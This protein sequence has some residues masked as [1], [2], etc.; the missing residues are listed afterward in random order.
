MVGM[1]SVKWVYFV[2]LF[3]FICFKIIFL[4]F[5]KKCF[6]NFWLMIFVYCEL[7]CLCW[8]RI[9][10]VCCRRL[11]CMILICW[12]G[13]FCRWMWWCLCWLRCWWLM[14]VFCFLVLWSNVLYWVGC[15]WKCV[16]KL[17]LGELMG[18]WWLV[19]FVV[20]CGI[21]RCIVYWLLIWWSVY[22]L[23]GLWVMC[24]CGCVS[25][26]GLSLFWMW[27]LCV[28]VSGKLCWLLFK[29]E[30]WLLINL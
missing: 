4:W 18:W 22:G 21:W 29:N 6:L 23:I 7:V 2:L 17:W 15:L 10:N 3:F 1:W 14:L 12:C 19:W 8:R 26:L 25:G 28:C 11:I 20:L 27:L 13:L 24:R 5:V 30:C 16:F 9:C